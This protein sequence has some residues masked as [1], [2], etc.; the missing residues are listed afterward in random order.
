MA[1]DFV[2]AGE[3]TPLAAPLALRFE[4]DRVLPGGTA[5]LW[6][7]SGR[8][9]QTLYVERIR[10]Q[11]IQ[12]RWTLT[13]GRDGAWLEIP[14]TKAD[15]G[16]FA[17][18]AS[19]VADHQ[20]VSDSAT[21]AVPWD[22]KGLA[23]DFTTFRDKLRPGS[24]ER[25]T[26][27]VKD[28]LGRP[29]GAGAAELVASMYDRSLDA[30]RPFAVPLASSL[31]PSFGLGRGLL[32]TLGAGRGVWQH[33][34][35]WR[36]FTEV[37]APTPDAFVAIDPYGIGGPG[38]RFRRGAMLAEGAVMMAGAPPPAPAAAVPG[39]AA[40]RSPIRR[41]PSLSRSSRTRC[42]RSP[43]RSLRAPVELRSN[44]AETAFFEP[45]LLTGADGSVAI[46][47][48][49]PDSVTSWKVWAARGDAR[50]RDRAT[51][52]RAPRASRS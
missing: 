50:P 12:R 24:R 28:H 9:G 39:I 17:V 1:T 27:R 36:S 15:R 19:L 10:D 20:L 4:S 11:E 47:F 45:H 35:D 37:E 31:Y 34:E 43:A 32:S 40:R 21:L 44:F 6:V 18:R 16:G 33:E 2:V 49:V 14:V 13:A 42:S 8:P 51:A 7:H 5:R 23:V 30:L 26:I 3:T 48:E 52:R 41:P 38:M 25:F 29:L 46:E 22:D